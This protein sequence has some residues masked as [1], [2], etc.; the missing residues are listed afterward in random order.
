MT[1]HLV[2]SGYAALVDRINLFP[3]GA[4]PSETLYK[5]LQILFSEKDA[6]LVSLLPIKP[7]TVEKAARLWKIK[8]SEARRILDNLAARAILLDMEEDE[9]QTYVLPPPMAGFLSFL[10]CD[11]GGILTR[12]R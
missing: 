4:P 10:S 7:F 8:P 9:K 12:K 1:H 6:A 5:I 2:K 11:F 3:Q